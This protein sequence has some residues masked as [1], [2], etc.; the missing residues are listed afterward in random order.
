M[1][2]DPESSALVP[3]TAQREQIVQLLC[4]HFANDHLTVEELES[5]LD[6]AYQAR[7]IAELSAL[8]EG[9]PAAIA[10]AP[11]SATAPASAALV[12]ARGRI[13]AVFGSTERRGAMVVPAHLQV[14]AVFGS[15][16]LDLRKAMFGP[17][18]TEIHASAVLG[19]IALYVPPG[20]Q[21]ESDGSPV[22]GS[23]EVNLPEGVSGP[24]PVVRITGRAVLGS[25]EARRAPES[26]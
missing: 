15:V 6:R 20:V 11:A 1:A 13:G 25:V 17:G 14:T 10:D 26:E 21:V 16:E 5:R 12:P 23:F 3:S 2:A 18:V 22:L 8:I 4:T 9:L 7:S 19:S 24:G